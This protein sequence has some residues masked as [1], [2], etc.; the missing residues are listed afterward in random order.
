MDGQ[1]VAI[2]FTKKQERL[3]DD[4]LE[5]QFQCAQIAFDRPLNITKV[6]MR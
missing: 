5:I 2:G 1:L 3:S 4:L 6:E